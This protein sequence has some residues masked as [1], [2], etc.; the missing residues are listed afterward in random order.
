M[1]D[2][3]PY[4]APDADLAVKNTDSGVE[5]VKKLPRFT[6][7]AVFGLSIITLGIY[8]YYWLY[9]RTKQLNSLSAP[10]NKIASW[11]PTTTIAFT[12]LYWIMSFVPLAMEGMA[13]PTLV[14]IIGILSL[15]I[16]IVYFVLYIMWIF[17]FR[18]CLTHLSGANKGEQFWL[19]GIMTFFFNVIYFQYK[20]NQ[21]HDKG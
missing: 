9:T 4:S 19:G 17:A 5:A 11:L 16:S 18:R 3:N 13:D 6:A 1:S 8:G 10:E 14:M 15:V 20:I 12:V 2:N 7:W 21:M